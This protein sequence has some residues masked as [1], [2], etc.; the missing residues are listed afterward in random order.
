MAI[1]ERHYVDLS[2]LYFVVLVP[3]YEKLGMEKIG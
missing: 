3:G 2:S 1:E